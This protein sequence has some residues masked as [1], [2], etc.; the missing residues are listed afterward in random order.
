M[1]DS[2]LALAW[3]PEWCPSLLRSQRLKIRTFESGPECPAGRKKPQ[4]RKRW[5]STAKEAGTW[6]GAN[7]ATNIPTLKERQEKGEATML[8]HGL[9][10][11][12]RRVL[13]AMRR[14]GSLR[15]ETAKGFVRK[16]SGTSLSKM[17]PSGKRVPIEMC[18]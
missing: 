5:T 6:D 8:G 14:P 16:E 11:L 7:S 12:L 10:F 17:M 4:P 1:P 3:F 13:C 15:P 2:T 18:R 9:H